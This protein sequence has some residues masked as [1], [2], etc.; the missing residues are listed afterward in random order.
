MPIQGLPRGRCTGTGARAHR[1]QRRPALTK[2]SG[3]TPSHIVSNPSR[4]LWK[5]FFFFAVISK[6]TQEKWH[7]PHAAIF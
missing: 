5:T 1:T 3:R 7:H 4:K 6:T 2:K